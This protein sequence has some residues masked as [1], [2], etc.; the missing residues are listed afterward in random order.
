MNRLRLPVLLLLLAATTTGVA[1]RASTVVEQDLAGMVGEAAWILE[2]E[3]LN[4]RCVRLEDGRIETRYELATLTPMKG[5]IPSWCELRVPGGEIAG[6]GMLIAGMPR[7]KLGDRHILF[8][9]EKTAGSGWR[10][11]VGLACG[12]YKVVPEASGRL[13]VVRD[14]SALLPELPVEV[15]DHELFVRNVIDEVA[16]QAEAR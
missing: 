13:S 12:D 11:P 6:K 7:L 14:R 15:M 10:F 8:L 1:V 3:V 4:R 2:A 9:S 5:S 16:R